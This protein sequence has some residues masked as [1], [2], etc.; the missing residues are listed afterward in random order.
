M[1]C[2]EITHATVLLN[3]L[4][5]LQPE[6][7]SKIGSILT[8]AEQVGGTICNFLK[9][10]V[11]TN[12]A[13]PYEIDGNGGEYFMDDANVPS[14]LS[15]PVLGFVSSSNT[16][17][18]KTRDLV[19]SKTNPFYYSGRAADGIGG[20]H[21][22]SNFAWPMAMVVKSMTSND[23]A[24][25]QKYLDLLIT[26]TAGTGLMHES[27]NVNDSKDYTRSWFAWAN[28][29]FG[30]LVLQLIHT[31]PT[32]VLKNDPDTIAL[33]QSLVKIPIV[34]EAQKTPLIN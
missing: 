5:V 31:H 34:I 30:E 6:N 2:V 16:A 10:M 13:L 27:F 32:L 4:L 11:E 9:Q 29:L 18:T 20:P 19:W 8:E 21:V 28:G 24:E 17:Y 22:G 14:L 1:I 15:L 7:A 3:K 12:Q 25:I 26:N 23:E 33:A